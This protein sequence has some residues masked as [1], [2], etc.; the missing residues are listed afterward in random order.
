MEIIQKNL[1]IVDYQND[2]VALDGALTCG[3]PAIDIEGNILSLVDSYKGKNIFVTYDTH[4]TTDWDD[5][6][7]TNEANI[8]NMHC[9]YNT[10]GHEIYGKLK[11]KLESIEHEDVYKNSYA[12]EKLVRAIMFKNDPNE[13]IEIE[14]CGVATNVCVFQCIL[15]VYN[16]LV[17]NDLKFSITLN[18]QCVA[19]FDKELEEQA[20]KYLQDVLGVVVK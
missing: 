9:V 5:D 2:F 18:R 4:Y 14:F 15:L 8:F 13:K 6:T 7:K 20:I 1:V 3:Q 19:S 17:Q 16:Y 12:T 10:K 11:E